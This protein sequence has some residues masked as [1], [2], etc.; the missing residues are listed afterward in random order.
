MTTMSLNQKDFYIEVAVPVPLRHQFTYRADA[1]LIEKIKIGARVMVPFG[2][3]LLTGYAVGLNV[4]PD[5]DLAPDDIK[6]VAELVDEE[7]LISEEILHLTKWAADY[8]AASWGEL[9]KAALPAGINTTIEK[10]VTITDL[11]R[12]EAAKGTGKNVRQRILSALAE[13]GEAS[14]SALVK[15][16]GKSAR[17]EVPKLVKD[18][19]ATVSLQT[20]EEKAKPKLHR[21]VRLLNSEDDKKLSPAQTKVI[22]S[23]KDHHGEMPA[24]DLIKVAEVSA[25]VLKTLEKCGLI[26]IAMEEVFRDPLSHATLPEITDLTL[27]NEQSSVFAQIE[28]GILANS[29]HAFLLHGVTG[30]GKT[31]IYIRAM[32]TALANGKSALM[33][34]PEIALTPIFSRRLRAIFGDDVAIL[35]SSLSTGERFDE[36]RRLKSGE[37]RIAIGTRSAVFAPLENLGVVIV[38]EEH[39]ASYRQHEMPFYNGRDAAIVRA[40]QAG[41]VVVLGSATP[42]LESFYNAQGKKYEY[43]HLPNRIGNRPLAQ[44]ELIDMRE[45]FEEK[46]KD[47]VFSDQLLAAIEETHSQGEQSIILLNRRGYSSF[48]LCRSCGESIKCP[49]CDITLTFHKRINSLVCHY[50]NFRRRAPEKCPSC[51]SHFLYYVGEGTEQLADILL[52]K[53]PHIRSARID[54]DTI[55]RRRLFEDTIIDFANGDIDMLVGT[56]M[57]AKG[58]D[59]PNVTLVGV[60][61]VDAGLGM[62]DFRSAERTFQLLTQVAGRA[63]RGDKP[64]RVLIQTFHPEHYALQFAQ[65]Q[66]YQGF[67]EQEI[68]F[69]ER[70]GFPPFVSLASVLVHYSGDDHAAQ[71]AQLMRDC[72]SAA[73]PE[74][75]VVILGPAPAPI[76]RLKNEFRMQIL[77]KSTNRKRLRAVLDSAMAEAQKRGAN[78]RIIKIEIDP[79]NLM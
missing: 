61:S 14:L 62:P 73:N 69:R 78:M 54:R 7:P 65:N 39:D 57:L 79:I 31:E 32:R 35:H 8:Y 17:A 42:A 27:T 36:W 49:H 9:L 26:E 63:G 6:D 37:A 43:L 11:G 40:N 44:A 3:Q 13:S 1:E 20:G 25:S 70:F 38:D 5:A 24:P 56:Q 74:K 55:S 47:E 15:Q 68:G 33:L 2:R 51:E 59:F 29:Y 16:H 19:F 75:K 71:T 45:A 48:I 77:L 30:S 58:H 52:Q 66:D 10:L 22:E 76:A 72:L 28:A 23:L 4:T 50:C 46:G 53:F 60:V 12:D 67:Y 64:G 18:G 21:V 34:V 41:A